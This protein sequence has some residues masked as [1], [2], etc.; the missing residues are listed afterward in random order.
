[1]SY[2]AER[3]GVVPRVLPSMGR[4]IS[5]VHDLRSFMALRHIIRRYRPHV[6]HTHTAKAGTLGRLAGISMNL[7]RCQNPRIR[8]VHTYHGHVFHHYFGRG[9]TLFFMHIE[10]LLG[11]LTD[12]IIVLS[13][14]QKDDI[15]KRYKVAREDR[16]RVIPLGFELS[17]FVKEDPGTREEMRSRFFPK[18]SEEILAVGI[19][20]RLT[21]VKNHRMLIKA[22]RYLK[23][24]DIVER[25]KFLVIG[26]G[27]LREALMKEAQA[28]GVQDHIL[29]TGWLRD[30]PSIY[31]ALDVVVLTSLNEGTPVTLI[32]AM[33]AGVPV[34]A[35][36]VGGVRDLMGKTRERTSDG[37]DLAGHG[38]LVPS[39]DVEAFAKAL[40]FCLEKRE[41]AMEMAARAKEF[42]LER[43]SMDRLTRDLESLYREVLTTGG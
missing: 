8:L 28:L 17:D 14:L 43:Y 31:R 27:E 26:G 29:F 12:R 42:V 18:G 23:A 1:M 20:G 36:D 5:P 24:A 13:P 16:V 22:V 7:T 33:A 4:E 21:G 11:R 25:F 10:R 34:V 39:N 40:R 37:Y 2:L 35:T 9:K 38:V 32:E 19:I 6:I 15:C 3:W 30:M 41:V